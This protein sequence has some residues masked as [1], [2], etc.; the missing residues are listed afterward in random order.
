[1]H[2]ISQQEKSKGWPSLWEKKGFKWIL[3]SSL[4]IRTTPIITT[5]INSGPLVRNSL[6]MMD[7]LFELGNLNLHVAINILYGMLLQ[8]REVL[9]LPGLTGSRGQLK[10]TL[11]FA[12]F[13]AL[14]GLLC[15]TL[16]CFFL[17][18]HPQKQP[19][20]RETETLIKHHK[21]WWR[22]PET[23]TLLM[24]WAK[25]KEKEAGLASAPIRSGAWS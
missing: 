19:Q 13:I 5:P 15:L 18:H 24:H 23:G 8:P 11:G 9:P 16:D 21:L 22:I 25:W 7:R 6:T 20:D 1:M 17:G 10:W 3:A 4:E 14:R 12:L 2:L